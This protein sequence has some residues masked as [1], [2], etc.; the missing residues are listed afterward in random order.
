[1]S[2]V[3]QLENIIMPQEAFS[4][5]FSYNMKSLLKLTLLYL[6]YCGYVCTRRLPQCQMALKKIYVYIKKEEKKN[7][8]R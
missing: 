7:E 4:Y 8:M 5:A 1:M 6:R 3:T 2:A